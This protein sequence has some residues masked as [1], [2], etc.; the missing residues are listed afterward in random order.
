MTDKSQ[1]KQKMENGCHI[2][3]GGANSLSSI[4]RV[5]QT[6]R[7][8][9]I[10]ELFSRLKALIHRHNVASLSQ[11]YC[12]LH[13][14]YS[15][16]PPMKTFTVSTHHATTTVLN[17]PRFPSY[18]IGKKEAPYGQV[19]PKSRGF[20][21]RILRKCFRYNYKINLFKS[22]INRYLS[23]RFLII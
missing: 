9:G 1:T 10:V 17:H 5:L 15:L 19:F 20:V 8:L 16:V 22:R 23:C 14:T 18:S 7:D 12:H 2:C 3:D 21:K 6:L 4:D 13:D 11:R